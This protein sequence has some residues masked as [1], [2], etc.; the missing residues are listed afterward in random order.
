MTKSAQRL[1]QRDFRRCA[2]FLKRR[3]ILT[4]CPFNAV[5]GS[6]QG[7]FCTSTC[8]LSQEKSH[9]STERHF[10]HPSCADRSRHMLSLFRLRCRVDQLTEDHRL[11]LQEEEELTMRPIYFPGTFRCVETVRKCTLSHGSKQGQTP[12]HIGVSR[13]FGAVPG[14]LGHRP[15][16]AKYFKALSNASRGS[17]RC[18]PHNSC[19]V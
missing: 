11:F 1:Q 17:L 4:S 15:W 14:P 9:C 13:I 7:A 8:L 10:P 2:L 19:R 18:S 5:A 12:S 6:T 16:R 3:I